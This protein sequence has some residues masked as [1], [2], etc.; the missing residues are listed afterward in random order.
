MTTFKEKSIGYITVTFRD[1][2]GALASPTVSAEYKILDKATGNTI[3]DW[4]A[5]TTAASIEITVL[6]ADNAIVNAALDYE[7]HELIAHGVYTTTTDEVYDSYPFRVKN[8]NG[9]P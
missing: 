8:L 1:K 7:E 2:A 4:T 5:L 3:K 6:P 9:V